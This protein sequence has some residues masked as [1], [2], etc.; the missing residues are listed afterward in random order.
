M[1]G[2]EELSE[3]EREAWKRVQSYRGRPLTQFGQEIG[4]R[5]AA[6]AK[7]VGVK[8]DAFLERHP[9]VNGVA[10]KGRKA[11][12]AGA[13]GV[14][15]GAAKAAELVPEKVADWGP[16]A[17][18]SMQKTGARLARVGL[19]PAWILKKHRKR[20][21]DVS[22]LFH[23]RRLD[24]KQIDTVRGVGASW[25]YP[26]AAAMS[27][28]GA[29]ILVTGSQAVVTVGAGAAAAPGIGVI[30]GAMA[31]DAAFLLGVSSRAV[32]HV[33]LQYG[34]DPEDPAEKL[35][36]LSVINL[37]TAASTSSKMAALGDLSK[38]TQ[39]LMRGRT[40]EVLLNESVV[41]RVVHQLAPRFGGRLYK[42]G[43]GKIVPAIGIV[44]GGTMN[45]AALEG[46]VDAAD[47][48]YRRR[49]L[50]EK[51]PHL[52]DD[53]PIDLVPVEGEDLVED[54]VISVVDAIERA[55]EEDDEPGEPPRDD[56]DD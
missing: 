26:A 43:L 47:L 7:A 11:L 56:S 39:N 34:Y 28:V 45:W 40:W 5:V 44:I 51:Y 15:K 2:I 37:G 53:A 30:A 27:G 21:H 23:L 16:H 29:G 46:I 50:I 6:G 52:A 12:A 24:L 48:A 25:Y 17:I 35:F 22:E 31:G 42:Q 36:I 1:N 41:A 55:S 18:A 32:G 20:G 19:S 3:Y 13:G 4:E 10:D 14:R 33:A 38:L 54:E 9:N 49:F 8:T